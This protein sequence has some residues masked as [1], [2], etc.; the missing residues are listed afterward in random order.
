MKSGLSSSAALLPGIVA[1]ALLAASARAD[2]VTDWNVIANALVA[3]DW[4][5]DVARGLAGFEPAAE[6]AAVLP[7]KHSK[8]DED[9]EKVMHFLDEFRRARREAG[10]GKLKLVDGEGGGAA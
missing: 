7:A 9:A 2:V 10:A 3:K 5:A 4:L 6:T 1:A 8:V